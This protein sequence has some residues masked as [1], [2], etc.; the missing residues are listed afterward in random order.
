MGVLIG[1]VGELGGVSMK[2][3]MLTQAV[4]YGEDV[5]DGFQEEGVQD[6]GAHWACKEGA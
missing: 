3:G 5:G 4:E 1:L 2:V 6:P